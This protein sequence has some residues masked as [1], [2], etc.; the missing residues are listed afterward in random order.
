MIISMTFS[1]RTEAEKYFETNK[2]MLQFWVMAPF[3]MFSMS[4]FTLLA[5]HLQSFTK[6]LRVTLVFM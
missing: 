3:L 1:H 2:T 4:C 5:V 6:Y